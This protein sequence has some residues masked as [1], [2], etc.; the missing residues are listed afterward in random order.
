MRVQLDL[1][2]LRGLFKI[3][4]PYASPE[5]ERACINTVRPYLDNSVISEPHFADVLA[6]AD[7]KLVEMGVVT[8]S[9]ST[10]SPRNTHSLTGFLARRSTKPAEAKDTD[11]PLDGLPT[12]QSLPRPAGSSE[13]RGPLEPVETFAPVESALPAAGVSFV[14]RRDHGRRGRGLRLF[15]L[16]R[17]LTDSKDESM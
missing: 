8:R 5:V 16:L 4:Y 6:A 2:E 1:D 3:I 13:P 11:P 9:A 15:R 14:E 12:A 7:E 17:R 10:T